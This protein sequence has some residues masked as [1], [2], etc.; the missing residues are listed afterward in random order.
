[1]LVVTTIFPDVVLCRIGCYIVVDLLDLLST[2]TPMEADSPDFFINSINL[3]KISDVNIIA[4]ILKLVRAGI[5]K[6]G[7]VVYS[8][9]VCKVIVLVRASKFAF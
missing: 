4:R 7:E 2:D 1:M 6:S 8:T 3:N 5:P 9:V